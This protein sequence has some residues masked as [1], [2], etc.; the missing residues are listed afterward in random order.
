[1][2]SIPA[3]SGKLL[4]WSRDWREHL[5]ETVVPFNLVIGDGLPLVLDYPFYIFYPNP[6]NGCSNPKCCWVYHISTVQT[7]LSSIY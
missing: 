4:Y 7:R 2:L 6:I 5:L 3:I 1:M